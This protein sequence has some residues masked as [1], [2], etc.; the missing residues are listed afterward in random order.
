MDKFKTNSPGGLPLILN[1][2]RQFFGRL[3]SPSHGI[4]QAFNNLLK[5]FSNDALG[6]DF[7]IQ[8]CIASG[9]TPNVAITEGW[10]LLGGELIKVDA[11]TGIDTATDNKFVKVQTFDPRGTK[12]FQNSTINETY[13]KNRAVIQGT[14]GNLPFDGFRMENLALLQRKGTDSDPEDTGIITLLDDGRTF[15]IIDA[16]GKDADIEFITERPTG[17]TLILVI[18]G[19]TPRTILNTSGGGLLNDANG[20]RTNRIRIDGAS[21]YKTT[22]LE[23]LIF[24]S[25]GVGTFGG[26]NLIG[27]S[28]IG[29]ISQEFQTGW[30]YLDE[31]QLAFS[32]AGTGTVTPVSVTLAR[33][34][35]GGKT[36]MINISASLDLSG[37]SGVNAIQIGIPA[38]KTTRFFHSIGFMIEEEVGVGS[39][40]EIC[41]FEANGSILKVVRTRVGQSSPAILFGN[42]RYIF[43]T[44]IFY[45]LQ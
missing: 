7:I 45:E 27:T 33:R 10:V 8:G 44:Q 5:G 15:A 30:E 34:I 13:E 25:V 24:Q 4:Y 40:N 19:T 41:R 14:S 37:T 21:S 42:F 18:D 38:V 36:R 1:D 32:L 26:W 17:T 16:S 3:A 28:R 29:A 43:Q 39:T 23:I 9:T 35:T 20:K 22:A 11:Q 6:N 12:T 31:T 2:L